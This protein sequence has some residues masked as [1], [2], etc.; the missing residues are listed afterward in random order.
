MRKTLFLF[1]LLGQLVCAQ[2]IELKSV[3]LLAGTEKGGFYH[4]VFSPQ[5]NYILTTFDDYQ[6]LNCH[7]LATNEIKR[8]TSDLGAGYAVRISNDEN[9][10]LYRKYNFVQNV[11]YSSLRKYTMNNGRNVELIKPTRENIV[12]QFSNNAPVYLR[13]KKMLKAPSA[14]KSLPLITI[15]NKKMVLYIDGTAR[16]LTPN[17]EN[18]SYFWTSISPDNRHIVYTTARGGTFVCDLDGKNVVSIGYLNSPKWLNNK[19]LVGM[20]DVDDGHKVLSSDIVAV[21]IDGKTRK[22]FQL[23][24]KMKAMYPA[25][26]A[27]GKKIAFNTLEGKI[28]IME[29]TIK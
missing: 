9:T 7:V 5:G 1:L 18:E 17:G 28:Y 2:Q 21:S 13:G 22:T 3:R 11:R 23:P 8:L 20:N 6:G 10:I 15:E 24:K 25:P 12:P 26:S 19:W 29:I 27:D 14:K 4:P 16:V